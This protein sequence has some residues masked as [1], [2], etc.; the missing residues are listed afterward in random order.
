MEIKK[1]ICQ[2]LLEYYGAGALGD[3]P[4]GMVSGGVEGDSGL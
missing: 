3:D 2:E 1:D 4:G